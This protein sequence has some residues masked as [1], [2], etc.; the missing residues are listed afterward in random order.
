M[1][2]IIF[3]CHQY[4]HHRYHYSHSFLNHLNQR[5]T[6]MTSPYHSNYCIL[7]SHFDVPKHH[8]SNHHHPLIIF[9]FLSLIMCQV[10]IHISA[11]PWTF[12]LS[13]CLSLF[14]QH[15]HSCVLWAARAQILVAPSLQRSFDNIKSRTIHPLELLIDFACCS[16]MFFQ[17]N[18]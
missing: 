12:Q 10:Y 16:P 5:A 13:R 4:D 17:C 15:L 14:L 6:V 1:E 3:V 7:Y 8:H 9:S 2:G 11:K 18:S